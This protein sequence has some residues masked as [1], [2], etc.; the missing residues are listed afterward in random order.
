DKMEKAKARG[1]GIEGERWRKLFNNAKSFF[2]T[3]YHED[4]STRKKG[5]VFM[6]FGSVVDIFK[7]TTRDKYRIK[8]RFIHFL[9]VKDEWELAKKFDGIW[10][11]SYKLR[12]MSAR[13]R[14]LSSKLRKVG[15][16]ISRGGVNLL[17]GPQR[18]F[19]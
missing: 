5:E 15:E 2:F 16:R 18:S 1:A 17:I 10:M 8:Y 9:D 11:S 3:N 4:W 6:R 14:S 19:A 13:E 7:P 12:V